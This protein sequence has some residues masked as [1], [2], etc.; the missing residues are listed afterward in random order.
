MIS[1]PRRL[2][3]APRSEFSDKYNRISGVRFLHLCL[4]YT[5]T[6]C[7]NPKYI[8]PRVSKPLH[9]CSCLRKFLRTLLSPESSTWGLW[10]EAECYAGINKELDQ[11]LHSQA[12]SWTFSGQG[13]GR[14]LWSLFRALRL[15]W[16]STNR[17]MHEAFST[18]RLFVLWTTSHWTMN[19][20]LPKAHI[21]L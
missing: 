10:V 19:I 7:L 20:L 11:G 16:R 8:L 14:S 21:Y 2:T 3:D 6:A 18:Q 9:P 17:E 15:F 13:L 1:Q 4:Y 12:F 5:C